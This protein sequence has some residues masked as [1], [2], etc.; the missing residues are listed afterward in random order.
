MSNISAV[1]RKIEIIL[2]PDSRKI[3]LVIPEYQRPYRWKEE[4]VRQLLEDVFESWKSGKNAYRV[5]SIILHNEKNT[6][7]HNV[8]DGQQRLTT[9]LLILKELGCKVGESLRSK[10][11]YNHIDSINRIIENNKYIKGWIRENISNETDDFSKYLT[12]YCEFVE[13]IVDDLTE[14]FQMF[15]SQNGRGKE[16]ESYNLLKAYHIRAME[17]DTQE[18]KIHCDRKW[19][20][21]TRVQKS[22]RQEIVNDILKQIFSEQL[23]RTRVWSKKEDAYEFNKTKISEF[24]GLTINKNLT[25]QYPFQN[26]ELLHYV[27]QNYFQQLGLEVKG[28]KNRFKNSN[29]ENINPFVL[30]NQ[31]ILNGKPFFEYIETYV[32]IYKQLFESQEDKSEL[33]EF[34]KFYK[35]NCTYTGSH[36]DGDKYLKELYKSL[37]FLMFDKFGE[38]GLLKYY[39]TLFVLVYR[40]RLIKIQVKY[41]A[42]AKYPASKN[43]F[44][45]INQSNSI[46]ELQSLDKMVNESFECKKV[47]PSILELFK[48]LSIPFSIKEN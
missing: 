33:S 20:A 24:K 16:L 3:D 26:K 43:L 12:Q 29:F 36:R 25:I 45:I 35:K 6:Q 31:K 30:I 7:I 13:I 19:E 8:V 22:E 42:I 46:L 48:E 14:A 2:D 15:D 32:E 11:N 27:L 39:K 44:S 38:E 17:L 1:I 34:K 47:V 28:I 40:E 10:L 23:Y 9:I 41:A 5:G 4:N 21:A 18:A 37:V